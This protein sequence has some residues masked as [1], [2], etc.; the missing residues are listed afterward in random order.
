LL[1]SIIKIACCKDNSRLNLARCLQDADDDE[2]EDTGMPD[3]DE[4]NEEEEEDGEGDDAFDNKR[5]VCESDKGGDDRPKVE[6]MDTFGDRNDETDAHGE[7]VVDDNDDDD[8]DNDDDDDDDDD[9]DLDTGMPD[10]DD[11]DDSNTSIQALPIDSC[12]NS[13]NNII[14]MS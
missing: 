10:D 7:E 11:G 3:D 5:G 4:D 2:A 8:D 13:N 12:Y 14:N 6:C 1:E 9:D